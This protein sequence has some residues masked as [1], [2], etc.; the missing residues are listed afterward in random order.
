M[1]IYVCWGAEMVDC[2]KAWEVLLSQRGDYASTT[3]KLNW[4]AVNETPHQAVAK[5]TG[6]GSVCTTMTQELSALQ[7]L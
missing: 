7:R 5:L 1:E 2:L 4:V 3:L 6:R